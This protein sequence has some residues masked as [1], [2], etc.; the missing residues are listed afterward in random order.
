MITKDV[1]LDANQEAIQL[2]VVQGVLF[3]LLQVAPR[4]VMTG[5]KSV[6]K[7]V[8]TTLQI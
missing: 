8:M 5:I 4:Y 2:G 7:L 1:K 6:L 3:Q